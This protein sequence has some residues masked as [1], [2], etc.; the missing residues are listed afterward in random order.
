MKVE[1]L[2]YLSRHKEGCTKSVSN[3]FHPSSSLADAPDDAFR[4]VLW[5]GL[6]TRA[7][8]PAR[9]REHCSHRRGPQRYFS[10]H[11]RAMPSEEEFASAANVKSLLARNYF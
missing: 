5:K 3:P 10:M 2:L 1:A 8:R 11:N 7:I 6:G 4:I 9:L